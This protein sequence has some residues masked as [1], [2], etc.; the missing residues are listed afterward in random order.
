[1]YTQAQGR[2]LSYYKLLQVI[3]IDSGDIIKTIPAI[4][5]VTQDDYL[6][7]ASEDSLQ[8]QIWDLRHL[9]LLH[10]LKAMGNI[11]KLSL[12]VDQT[13]QKACLAAALANGQIQVWKE[14]LPTSKGIL[15]RAW[16]YMISKLSNS[17]IKSIQ[18]D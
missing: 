5:M 15:K 10:T 8:I 13:K 11:S 6:F 16:S 9:T 12:H 2:W 1:M 17:E 3:Q 7:T 14:G 18:L 4:T